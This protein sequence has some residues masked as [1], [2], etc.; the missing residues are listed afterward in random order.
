MNFLD[1]NIIN[2]YNDFP[3]DRMYCTP[4]VALVSN[5]FVI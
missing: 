1:D 2:A 5:K 3:L 4:S